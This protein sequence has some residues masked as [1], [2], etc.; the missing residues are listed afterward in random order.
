MCI[1]AALSQSLGKAQTQL[2][3]WRQAACFIFPAVSA[4]VGP[5][6]TPAARIIMSQV[7][8]FS[9]STPVHGSRT[10]S[11]MTT[12][13]YRPITKHSYTTA[14]HHHML[15]DGQLSCDSPASPDIPLILNSP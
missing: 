3:G 9:T 12:G 14:L 4:S 5:P 7:Q 6:R 13:T 10:A 1:G 15:C 11:D 2:I 8:P